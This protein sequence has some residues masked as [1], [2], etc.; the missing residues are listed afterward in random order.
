M[1]ELLLVDDDEAT[2]LIVSKY[3][4]NSGYK[5]FTARNGEEGFQLLNK[6]ASI[7]MVVVDVV[8]P[9]MDGVAFCRK[10]RSNYKFVN[11]PILMLTAMANISDKYVGFDAG[12]DDYLTKPFEPLELLLRVQALMKRNRKFEQISG[13][14][15]KQN[16]DCIKINKETFSVNIRNKE[17][18]MTLVE[19]DIISYLF[20][21]SGKPISVE[22]I[23][24]KVMRYPPKTGN[25]ETIR[26]HI[27][28]IRAKIEID[29][30][31]P[32]N[33]TTVPKRGYMFNNIASQ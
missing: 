26:T 9:V 28:N 33:I 24:Q 16:N 21:N 15:E 29:S 8:M 31:N 12:A 10:M 20:S 7:E 6:E 30:S 25:P 32:K 1:K 14:P 17:I 27:K 19:F 22:E 4:N 13:F 5:I 23:L 11:L 3:L 18:Y 2:L